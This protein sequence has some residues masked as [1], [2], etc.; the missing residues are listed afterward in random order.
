MKAKK[1]FKYDVQAETN[2]IL[3]TISANG[4]APERPVKFIMSVEFDAGM[5]YTKQTIFPFVQENQCSFNVLATT[6]GLTKID[7][8]ERVQMVNKMLRTA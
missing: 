3:K 5:N 7:K 8:I 4:E 1:E 6:N 2:V